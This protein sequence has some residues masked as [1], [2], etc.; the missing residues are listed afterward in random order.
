M[1]C[2]V[3]ATDPQRPVPEAAH[4]PRAGP[5]A[6][7]RGPRRLGWEHLASTGR[8]LSLRAVARDLGVVSS[9]VY[10]YVENRE[11]L[12]TLLL[13]DAYNEL[14]DAVDAAGGSPSRG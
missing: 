5:A 9:A 13:V 12:L 3:S 10:R 8:R 4:A 6:D 2:W 14:G 11:E 7:H 1:E